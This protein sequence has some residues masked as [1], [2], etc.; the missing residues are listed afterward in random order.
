MKAKEI[1]VGGTYLAKVSGRI[2]RVRVTGTREVAQGRTGYRTA[3]EV[4]SLATGRRITVHSPQR[5][6]ERV[7]VE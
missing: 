5:F 7:E 4:T 6:R 3:W 2:V 1:E